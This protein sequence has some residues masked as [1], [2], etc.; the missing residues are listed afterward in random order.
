[1]AYSVIVNGKSYLTDLEWRILTGFKKRDRK[2]EIMSLALDVITDSGPAIYG[3]VLVSTQTDRE[4]TGSVGFYNEA[5]KSFGG[6][7]RERSLAAALAAG[8]NDGV[9]L[10]DLDQ[11]DRYWFVVIQSNLVIAGDNWVASDTL[12]T[13]LKQEFELI[14]P[15]LAVFTNIDDLS[16]PAEVD[17]P[18]HVIDR[19]ELVFGQQAKP[20]VRVVGTNISPVL[21][22]AILAILIVAAS[23]LYSLYEEWNQPSVQQTKQLTPAERRA[24]AT[25]NLVSAINAQYHADG[26]FTDTDWVNL[27][28]RHAIRIQ[29]ILPGWRLNQS[30]CTPGRGCRVHWRATVD[31]GAVRMRRILSKQVGQVIVDPASENVE[32]FTSSADLW[33]VLAQSGG[34]K[35]N[36]IGRLPDTALAQSSLADFCRRWRAVANLECSFSKPIKIDGFP[37]EGMNKLAYWELSIKE[38]GFTAFSEAM[39]LVRRHGFFVKSFTYIP[40]TGKSPASWIMEVGY[41]ADNFS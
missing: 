28:Y 3:V 23:F 29:Q 4:E 30:V 21:L 2:K 25:G 1:M 31:S 7:P 14:D 27:A 19:A 18:I 38:K 33:P 34:F 9:Y 5:T 40:V 12:N 37:Y 26:L 16:M 15:Q 22:V 24:R 39:A 8:A 6:A 11:G 10:F 32:F 17:R 35:P 13:F 20:F 36:S 41:V